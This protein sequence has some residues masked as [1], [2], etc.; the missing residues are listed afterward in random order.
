MTRRIR[1]ERPAT[2]GQAGG[3]EREAMTRRWCIEVELGAMTRRWCVEMELE[4][5]T[6]RRCVGMELEA[7][8]RRR[9]VEMELEVTSRH[10]GIGRGLLPRPKAAVQG[11][12]TVL[13]TVDAV[14]ARAA[15]RVPR[16]RRWAGAA[17][18]RRS[19][20]ARPGLFWTRQSTS[21][22]LLGLLLHNLSLR[23]R[24]RRRLL[25]PPG[26]LGRPRRRDP[27]G[28]TTRPR[29]RGRPRPP[30]PAPRRL[31]RPDPPRAA[32]VGSPFPRKSPAKTP[33]HP[34]QPDRG[35]KQLLGKS[36]P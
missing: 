1:D 33:P 7:M 15:A 5:M 19:V 14:G 22:V 21:Q 26:G 16:R 28:P 30:L 8:A 31:K 10:A 11:C 32:T 9:C 34:A 2:N 35:A 18:E 36:R 24:P 20:Q 4:A 13:R 29:G 25:C 6:R 23:A 3:G 27:P 17:A 12:R